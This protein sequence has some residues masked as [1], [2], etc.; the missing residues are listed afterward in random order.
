MLRGDSLGYQAGTLV[1]DGRYRVEKEINSKQIHP[2]ADVLRPVVVPQ[3]MYCFQPAAAKQLCN[4][5]P[6]LLQVHPSLAG[7]S[8]AAQQ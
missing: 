6:Q 5:L 4:R 8:Q 7:L 3:Y 2:L 1:R